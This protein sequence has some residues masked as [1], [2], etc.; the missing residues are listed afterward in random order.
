MYIIISRFSYHYFWNGRSAV[1]TIFLSSSMTRKAVRASWYH[2]YLKFHWEWI[3]YK[4]KGYLPSFLNGINWFE[5]QE[6]NKEV[7]RSYL[8]KWKKKKLPSISYKRTLSEW[9]HRAIQKDRQILNK[10][11]PVLNA[12]R[13]KQSSVLE[14]P[15]NA[16]YR[17]DNY[18]RGNKEPMQWKS[19]ILDWLPSR[20]EL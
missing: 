11:T 16:N 13:I 18:I 10:V 17:W 7:K 20:V 3:Q 8:V 12:T 9:I 4:K 19:R 5:V 14:R 2:P 6:N 15:F 1:V